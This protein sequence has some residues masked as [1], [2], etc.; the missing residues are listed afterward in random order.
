MLAA[1]AYDYET[2][3]LNTAAGIEFKHR[4]LRARALGVVRDGEPQFAGSNT[5]DPGIS[6]A[7][8]E[9]KAD[10]D[11][12]KGR[13]GFNNPDAHGTTVSLRTEQL[14]I[15]PGADQDSAWE[16]VLR[17]ARR[18][19]L[20]ADPDV[21]RYCLQIDPGDGLPVPGLVLSF[22][23]TIGPGVNLFGRELAAGDSTF[24]RS[25]F[26]TKI[27]AAGV[28]LEGYRGM[29][30]PG[31]NGSGA[32]TS[33]GTAQTAVDS[34]LSDSSALAATPDVYL[35]PVGVDSMRTPPLGDTSEIRTWRVEDLAIPLPFNIGASGFS[36]RSILQAEDTLME[37]LFAMRKHQAFRPVPDASYFDTD[38]FGSSGLK[39]SE[40]TNSRLIGRSVWNSQWKL[41]IPG[42]TLLNNPKE[43]LDRFVRTVRDIKLHFV[44]YSYSGN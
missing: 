12:V 16:D 18:D 42:A 44:T 2:G 14:R 43:G 7:L 9:M 24:T 4:I 29:G 6:S 26:A 31:V 22:G 10:W 37:P 11:V 3:L 13:L 1:N 23:T 27:F 28:A 30:T 19:D 36:E 38:I 5:G 34:W 40:Y 32:A 33:G 25:A 21:R 39:R 8:A 41:I 15:L 35:I 20:L 17:Q